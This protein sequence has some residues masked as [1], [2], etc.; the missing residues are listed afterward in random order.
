[1][2]FSFHRLG[3]SVGGHMAIFLSQVPYTGRLSCLVHHGGHCPTARL[4][5]SNVLSSQ[6]LD[7]GGYRFVVM[8]QWISH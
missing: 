8:V 2:S 7:K 3:V 5:A 6:M 1:M 4:F